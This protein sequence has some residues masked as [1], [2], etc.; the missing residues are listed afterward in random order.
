[1]VKT[2]DW[3]ID[4]GPEGGSGGGRVVV[5]GP[6][7]LVAKHPTSYTGR[8]LAPLLERGQ[9]TLQSE[10]PPPKKRVAALK[11]IGLAAPVDEGAPVKK[12]APEKSGAPVKK[13]DPVKNLDPVKQGAGVKPA[14]RLVKSAGPLRA[15]AP[16]KPAASTAK[17]RPRRENP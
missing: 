11:E 15:V 5:E 6:P 9:Y 7:E 16:P 3:I 1:M 13:A 8:F 14:D 17:R 2:A 4:L 10:S 12:I